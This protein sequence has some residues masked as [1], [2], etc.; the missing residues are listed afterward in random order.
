M[1]TARPP[2]GVGLLGAGWIAEL[3][4]V[5]TLLASRR[6]RLVAGADSSSARLE[7][8]RRVSPGVATYSA[9]DGLLSH[10]EV[11]AV[12][13]ALPTAL[14][15]SAARAVFAA[16]KHL[17]LEK[18]LARALDDGREVLA[19]WRRAGTIAAIGYNFRR[20]LGFEHARRAV[21]EG[22][23]GPLVTIQGSFHWAAERIDGWRAD[24]EQGGGALVDILSHH[25]DLVLA[26]SAEPTRSVRCLIRSVRAPGDT[27]T[28]ELTQESGL[29]AQLGGSSAAGAP[30][31][32]L[33]VTGRK[34]R[35]RVDL[36][37]PVPDPIERRPGP[38]ARWTRAKTAL[39]RLHPARLLHSPGFEPSLGRSLEA[40]FEA[41]AE[42]RPASPSLEDGLAVAAVVDAAMAS[43][44]RGGAP[45]TVDQAAFAR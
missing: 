22:E 9:A 8:L 32:E 11:D 26:L 33:T 42:R 23:L 31:N 16:G 43:A 20:A 36:L 5:P 2:I 39:A 18:P 24:P 41:I 6:A 19:A 25:I 28:L 15:A 13:V 3:A 21:R 7:W 35:L 1:P 14:H 12:I 30:A 17:Y 45:V 37:S 29:V 38:G 40:F 44:N 34:G 10:S 27:S 4:H